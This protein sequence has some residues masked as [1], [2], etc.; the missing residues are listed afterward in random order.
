ML[1][2][3][4]VFFVEGTLKI[5]DPVGAISVHG[6]NGAWGVLSLGLFADGTYGDGWNGVPGKVTGLFYGD[7]QQF[8][9]QCIGTLTCF[10][11]VFVDHVTCSSSWWT[12]SSATASPPRSSWPAW[13]CRRWGRSRTPSSCSRREARWVAFEPSA[14]AGA[15]A[16]A[17]AGATLR[18]EAL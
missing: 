10:V 1:V 13:T 2:C 6:V 18:T 8:C 14:P 3:W 16:T 4:A 5:D 11:F 15:R 9:A 12:R 7:A 17:P